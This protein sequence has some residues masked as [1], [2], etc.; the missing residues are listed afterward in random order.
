MQAKAKRLWKRY[1]PDPNIVR[2]GIAVMG[3]AAGLGL[4]HFLMPF[5]C[6]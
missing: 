4:R 3:F 6:G 5:I 1:H 2:A